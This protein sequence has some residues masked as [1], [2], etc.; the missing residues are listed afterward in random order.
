ML[1]K[2]ESDKRVRILP[3]KDVALQEKYPEI[4]PN[5][6]KEGKI[7]FGNPSRTGLVP[8]PPIEPTTEDIEFEVE[9]DDGTI[10]TAP[11]EALELLE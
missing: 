5:K 3:L 4:N 2:F 1:G 11:H 8:S 10:V 9:L 7:K 6:G